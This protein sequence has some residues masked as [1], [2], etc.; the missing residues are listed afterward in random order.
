MRKR[1]AGR[2]I[3]PTT[4][5]PK[6]QTRINCYDQMLVWL[7]VYE[8]DSG[9]ALKCMHA[10]YVKVSAAPLPIPR[11][12]LLLKYPYCTLVLVSN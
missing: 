6:N 2:F 9:S 8:L 12:E 10:V 3:S 4:K 7:A 11:T 5:R 1:V